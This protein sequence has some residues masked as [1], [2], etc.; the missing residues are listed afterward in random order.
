MSVL[1]R[2][3]GSIP[4]KT[5]FSSG[6]A[7]PFNVTV[8]LVA[9]ASGLSGD[10]RRERGFEPAESGGI[11]AQR[12]AAAAGTAPGMMSVGPEGFAS[13]P[14]AAIQRFPSVTGP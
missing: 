1:K 2:V 7:L 5:T 3:C 12:V 10:A 9:H 4:E 6:R 8:G 14:V 11:Q 13:R